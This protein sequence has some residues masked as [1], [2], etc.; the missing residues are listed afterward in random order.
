MNYELWIMSYELW[1]KWRG[2]GVKNLRVFIYYYWEMAYTVLYTQEPEW[3][4]TAE[5]VELPGCVTF[6]SDME[7][8]EKMVREAIQAYLGSLSKQE[9]AFVQQRKTFSKELLVDDVN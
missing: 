5:V 1:V 7:E 9:K 2:K 8:A 6:G 4:Y 3:W